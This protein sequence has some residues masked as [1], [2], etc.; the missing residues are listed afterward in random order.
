MYF[1]SS[2]STVSGAAIRRELGGERRRKQKSFL[3]TAHPGTS[4]SRRD[5]D[6]PSRKIGSRNSRSGWKDPRQRQ[7][8]ARSVSAQGHTALTRNKE[9]NISHGTTAKYKHP[10][11]ILR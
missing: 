6:C 11:R 7:L 5:A 8:W 10:W 9:R 2:G 1:S 3:I 4:N